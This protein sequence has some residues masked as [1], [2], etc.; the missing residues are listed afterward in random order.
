MSI[1]IDYFTQKLKWDIEK[2]APIIA[3][4]GFTALD[5]TPNIHIDNWQKRN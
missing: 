2:I 1:N 5:Y 4:T 3:K